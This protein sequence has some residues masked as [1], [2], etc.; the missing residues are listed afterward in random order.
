LWQVSASWQTV[1]LTHIGV[2]S[3]FFIAYRKP[4]ELY[5]GLLHSPAGS[6][7]QAVSALICNSSFFFVLQFAFYLR[8][9]CLSSRKVTGW[10]ESR[11]ALSLPLRSGSPICWL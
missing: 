7:C 1:K 4:G 10:L 8:F 5:S 6:F 3:L 9:M 2:H 11:V